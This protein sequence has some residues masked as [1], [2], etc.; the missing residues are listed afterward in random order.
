MADPES[1]A[2]MA[3][4]VR[5]LENAIAARQ[6]Q[7]FAGRG[8]GQYRTSHPFTQAP[9]PARGRGVRG[10]RVYP[11]YGPPTYRNR[12]LIIR[13]PTETNIDSDDTQSGLEV[14]QDRQEW[15]SKHDASKMQLINKTVY[16][17]QAA[18]GN[19]AINGTTPPYSP[20]STRIRPGILDPAVLHLGTL[21]PRKPS[22]PQPAPKKVL[23]R[24]FCLTGIL[25]IPYTIRGLDLNI[26]SFPV[27]KLTYT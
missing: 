24:N 17:N 23:C 5:A 6:A 26:S 25:F 1:T 14:Q 8:R 18:K 11:R 3:R 22:P 12:Q 15:I 2:E 21:A 13:E 7:Q 9:Y 16:T 19:G 20:S 4:K 10:G 27:Y